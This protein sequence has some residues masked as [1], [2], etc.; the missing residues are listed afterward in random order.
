M[1]KVLILTSC[2]RS[3]RRWF[4]KPNANKST[5]KHVADCKEK[6]GQTK[7]ICCFTDPAGEFPR[8]AKI[9]MGV[10]N[11]NGRGLQNWGVVVTWR[12]G[13]RDG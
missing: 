4:F 9:K 10:V 3:R 8:D 6:L 7:L 13:D 2:S 12:F 1:H 5:G 11:I